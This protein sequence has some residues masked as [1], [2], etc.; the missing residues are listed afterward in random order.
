MSM[1]APLTPAMSGEILVNVTP[2][3][4]RVAFVENGVLQEVQIERARK[5]GLV[6]NIYKGTVR[7]VLP[8]MQAAFIDA[9]LERTAFLHASDI[10]CPDNGSDERERCL[11]GEA[12][13]SPAQ[14]NIDEL[15]REGQE[16]LVQVVKDPLGTKGARLT[17]HITIPARFLV[18]MPQSSHVGVSQRIENEAER[19]RLKERVSALAAEFGPGGY[20]ARTAAEDADDE[21]LR[22]DIAFLH[23]LWGEIGAR[24]ANERSGTLIHEDL[25]LVMRTMRDVVGAEV[26]K[27]RIDSRETFRKVQR[28]AEKFIPELVPRIEHYAG[29]RPIFDLYAIEDEIQRALERKVTLKSGGYLIIDQTEA[30]TTIDVNTGAFVGHRNLEETIFKTNLEASQAI[31]RQLRLRNLGGIIILDFIDMEDAEHR[32]QVLRSLEKALERDHARTHISEVSALGLVEMTRKRTR[33]SLEH[34]LCSTCPTCNGRGTL[35]TAETVCFEIFREI[36]REARQFDAQ[37]L[38]VLAS[39][40]VVDRL[41]DEESTAVAELEEFIGKPIQFQVET[42]Y[43]QEQFDVVLL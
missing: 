3:E 2:H 20:I 8:G 13:D 31:A 10:L 38:L 23:K 16:L 24:A 28:F 39:Q 30:M 17:T 26:E 27:V 42:L 7:R 22:A 32:R 37:Q 1:N 9:G 12:T 5:R 21:A 34:V 14:R 36:M 4:T 6:G 29:E 18:F 35:K 25:P 43:T 19:Q 40:E 33:E 11:K 15:L 41:L